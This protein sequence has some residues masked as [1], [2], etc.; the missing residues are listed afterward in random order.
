[1]SQCSD[2]DKTSANTCSGGC[3]SSR[4][5]S[6]GVKYVSKELALPPKKAITSCEGGCIKGEIARVTANILAY[7]LQRS[8]A[9]RICL[10][11]AATGNSGFFDLINRAQQ[12]L[13]I[14]GCPLQCGTE[15]IKKRSPEYNPTVIDVSQLYEFDRTKYFEIFD[16]PRQEIDERAE[17]LAAYI[18]ENFF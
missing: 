12:V 16:M 2:G 18:S 14:E 7:R 1:M 9:V 13:A 6:D 3:A 15:I 17:K 8:N 4:V 10:G 5:C 11:D